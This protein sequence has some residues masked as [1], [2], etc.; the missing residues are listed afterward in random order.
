MFKVFNQKMDVVALDSPS[1]YRL[2]KMAGEQVYLAPLSQE[3][4]IALQKLWR[5]LTETEKG[6]PQVLEV[7][8]R[9]LIVPGA[10][11][12]VAR[13]C[14]ADLCEQPLGGAD[15]IAIASHF[16]T[17]FIEHIPL[18][19]RDQSNE[20]RRFIT[21]VDAFYDRGVKLVVTADGLPDAL[22]VEGAHVF[23]FARTASRL[24]EMQSRQYWG[25][26]N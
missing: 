11:R 2:G 26:N 23:E 1:D 5:Q 21:L 13:F 6:K 9:E 19:G 22:Y 10:A 14:F 4:D 20:A 8:G 25:K 12:G 15:Y 16:R 24:M 18:L 7:Q 3:A 17:V